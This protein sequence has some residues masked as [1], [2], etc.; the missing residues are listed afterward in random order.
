MQY[1]TISRKFIKSLAYAGK[2]FQSPYPD[3]Y[4]MTVMMLKGSRIL[5]FSKPMVIIGI[6]GKSFGFFYFNQREQQGIEFLKNFPDENA[7][8]LLGGVLLPGTNMNTSWL[9]AMETIRLNFLSE[10]NLRVAYQ[11][12]RLLQMIH[13]YGRY[14]AQKNLPKAEMLELKRHMKIWEKLLYG[15]ILWLIYSLRR[16]TSRCSNKI[17][18]RFIKIAIGQYPAHDVVESRKR[19]NNIIEVF[20]SIDPLKPFID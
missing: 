9:L 8:R 13:V 17:L 20:E 4:A 14:Y 11:R 16:L 5:I 12:Y 3:F 19:C 2:F 10:F 7:T 1:A 18:S 15:S 6:S